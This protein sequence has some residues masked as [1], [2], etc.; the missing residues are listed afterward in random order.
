MASIIHLTVIA[1]AA[2]TAAAPLA[3]SNQPCLSS[4]F[5]LSMRYNDALLSLS[6]IESGN[7]GTLNIVGFDPA[8]YRGTPGE[9]P[10]VHQPN[11]SNSR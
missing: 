5:T 3:A 11:S 8:T 10:S 4:E 9:L 7:E 1:F 6:A 2:F